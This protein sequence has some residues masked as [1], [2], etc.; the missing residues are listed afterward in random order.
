MRHKVVILFLL[1]CCK[2][3]GQDYIT[4]RINIRDSNQSMS[5]FYSYLIDSNNIL[6]YTNY[7]SIVQYYGKKRINHQLIEGNLED[8]F[9]TPADIFETP[10]GLILTLTDKGIFVF[11][12]KTGEKRILYETKV[13]ENDYIKKGENGVF[14]RLNLYKATIE[15]FNL[16][17]L[18]SSYK[19]NGDHLPEEFYSFYVKGNTVFILNK[20]GVYILDENCTCL[21]LGYSIPTSKF[22]SIIFIEDNT[23]FPK[24]RGVFTYKQEEYKYLYIKELD[25]YFVSF[26]GLKGL[27]IE[28]KMIFIDGVKIDYLAEEGRMLQVYYFN[29]SKNKLF[30]KPLESLKLAIG[31]IRIDNENNIWAT[32]FDEIIKIKTKNQLFTT[33]D[34]GVTNIRG[35]AMDSK[36]KVYVAIPRSIVKV[37][38]LHKK[39]SNLKINEI[40]EG[41][42]WDVY[43]END[44]ILWVTG[45]LKDYSLIKYNTIQNKSEFFSFKNSIQLWSTKVLGTTI[46]HYDKN[47]LIIGGEF[48]LVL[49]NK[50][51][52]TFEDVFQGFNEQIKEQEIDVTDIL[53]YDKTLWVAT[54]SYG[55]FRLDE[56][57]QI[58]GRHFEKSKQL[59]LTSDQLHDLHMSNSKLYVGGVKGVDIIDIDSKKLIQNINEANGLPDNRI[60]NILESKE[61][62]WFATYNGLARMNKSNNNF[63]IYDESDGLLSDDFN[64]KS[65][66]QYND[67]LIVYGTIRGITSVNPYVLP[68][69]ESIKKPKLIETTFYN[70]NK[71][72][73]VTQQ[74]NLEE[75]TTI[76][77]PFDNNFISLSFG[78]IGNSEEKVVFRLS[79]INSN[80]V[81]TNDKNEIV[82]P[83]LSPGT[84]DLIIKTESNTESEINTLRY[85]LE[86]HKSIFYNNWFITLI[87]LIL[88]GLILAFY[89]FSKTK[90]LKEINLKLAAEKLKDKAY[91]AQM[92]PHFTF[93]IINNLKSVMLVKGE[94]EFDKY[95]QLFAKLL[96]ATLYMSD[97]EAILL[98]DEI[99]FLKSY[100]ELQVV[101]KGL[102]IIIQITVDQEN[103]QNVL[104]PPLL[105]QPIVENAIEHGLVPKKGEKKLIIDFSMKGN[106][107]IGII[108]DN[109]IGIEES[110]KAQQKTPEYKH[111]GNSIL[112]DRIKVNNQ[113]QESEIKMFTE[114]GEKG[115]TK[116]TIFIKNVSRLK[117]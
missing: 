92:N 86:V 48:G 84:Y 27:V 70:A 69:K 111:Y 10:E 60:A 89:F 52:E 97:Q 78:I 57:F 26:P 109:G 108:E 32:D 56:D 20:D 81:S 94:G 63:S 85:R 37:S 43:K 115:G 46:K 23:F 34:L 21:K 90:R 42:L 22:N 79:N 25:G 39:T 24:E 113:A 105:F 114:S 98:K 54:L 55:L 71:K 88:L 66:H 74:Y 117:T 104:I 62:F 75:L 47:R 102:K 19:I 33:I 68:R 99:A 28:K 4:E 116:V 15:K 51:T 14:W 67:S 72:S 30:S 112:R 41:T 101:R 11:N 18:I 76:K 9:F 13:V 107:L 64:R 2:L 7:G 110:Q 31:E 8:V 58:V 1:V 53:L 59:K 44:S 61:D 87:L 106:S 100:L 77:V 35:L 40:I 82:L 73:L 49:F 95:I 50:K 17:G 6:W 12:P 91:R 93:N 38:D 3:F 83:N 103:T 80:W 65:F 29:Q 5:T 16:E 36:K 96:R 45:H